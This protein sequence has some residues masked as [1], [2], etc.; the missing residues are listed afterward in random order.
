MAGER[1]R[2]LFVC[3][4][5][6]CRSPLA[7]VMAHAA[8]HDAEIDVLVES[9]GTAAIEGLSAEAGARRQ[10]ESIGLSLDAHRAQPVTREMIANATLVVCVTDRH[11][12]YLHRFFP[13]AKAKILSFDDVTGMGDIPDPYGGSESD[14]RDVREQLAKGMPKIVAALTGQKGRS[15]RRKRT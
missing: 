14:Y 9:S 12:D 1:V 10:A 4:G 11:R 7:Q 2:L 15:H 6:I 3:S 5:N 8:L 13:E